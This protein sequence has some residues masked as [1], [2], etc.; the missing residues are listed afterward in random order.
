MFNFDYEIILY[1]IAL[2]TII[3]IF[4]LPFVQNT[5]G[6]FKTS[7]YI[8]IYSFIIN[9]AFS[10]AFCYSFVHISLIY[11]LWVGT[12]AWL[13][14]KVIY[15]KFEGILK[16]HSDILKKKTISVPINNKIVFKVG[17]ENV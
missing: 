11:T 16:S 14:A 17:D 9:I 12:I 6:M 7:K 4:T 8:P 15:E 10:L 5:K 2:A 1:L 13:D 3:D